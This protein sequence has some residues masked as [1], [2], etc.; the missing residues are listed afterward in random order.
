MKFIH[1]EFGEQI[2][3]VTLDHPVG[4]RINFQM[5][6]EL[7]EA[8]EQVAKSDSRAL[9]IQGAGDDFAWAVTYETSY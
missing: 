9:L 5:R 1:L 7:L 4:N 2:A 3:T 6:K 8:F